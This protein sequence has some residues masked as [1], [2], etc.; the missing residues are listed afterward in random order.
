[1]KYVMM[2][3]QDEADSKAASEAEMAES[4]ERFNDFH[5]QVMQSGH[6][7]DAWRLHHSDTSTVVHAHS[8]KSVVR[9]GPYAETKE[10]LGG[11]Y[12]FE[13]ADLDEAIEIAARIPT[14]ESGYIEIRPV[15][16]G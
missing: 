2:V 15:F 9:D 12:L 5:G 4:L 7:K 3:Y 13:C 10:Q 8:G 6:L 16:G 11:F 1:M 14:S